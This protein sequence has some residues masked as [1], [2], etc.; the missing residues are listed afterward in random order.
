[1]LIDSITG[2]GARKVSISLAQLLIDVKDLSFS[3]ANKTHTTDLNQSEGGL[4]PYV[5]GCANR[6]Q[7]VEE[8]GQV[9]AD[10]VGEGAPQRRVRHRVVGERQQKWDVGSRLKEAGVA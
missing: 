9:D 8:G 6:G 2:L 4:N 3:F 1:M 7:A 10:A 5:P